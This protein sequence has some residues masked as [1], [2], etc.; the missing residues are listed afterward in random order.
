MNTHAVALV[1]EVILC[2]RLNLLKIFQNQKLTKSLGLRL[3]LS[4]AL[5]FKLKLLKKLG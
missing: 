2:E 5:F 3:S 4:Q 1:L